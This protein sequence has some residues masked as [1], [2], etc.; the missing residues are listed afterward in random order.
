MNFD[1]I[2]SIPDIIIA[3]IAAVTFLVAVLIITNGVI[4]FK[5]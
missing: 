3:L 5:R 1:D 2:I 4:Y